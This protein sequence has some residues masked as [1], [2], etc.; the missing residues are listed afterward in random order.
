MLY[1][2]RIIPYNLVFKKP[3]KTSRNTFKEKTVYYLKL[4]KTNHPEKFGIGE[5]A[6]LALLSLDDDKEFE[7][8]FNNII[9]QFCHKG[10]FEPFWQ[11]KYPSM[12]FAL[13][14]A[15]LDLE[16]GCCRR[17][18]PNII[19][20]ELKIMI[21]GLVWMNDADTMLTEALEL[22]DK[23]YDCIKFKVGALDFDSEC[24]LLE[25]FRKKHSV[26][27][28]MIRL[29]ANGAFHPKEAKEQLK[30]L[31]KFGI[32]SIEQP[33]K[34]EFMDELSELSAIRIIDIALDESLIGIADNSQ[35]IDLLKNIKPQYL[36]LKPTLLGGLA[37]TQQ[38]IDLGKKMQI[39][40]WITSALESNIGLN[41]IAQF[42]AIQPQ[43]KHSYHGLGT[44]S[45]YENNIRSPWLAEAGNLNYSNDSPWD[46][47]MF[48]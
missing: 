35:K 10:Q 25:K 8:T 17:L 34:P 30:E 37:Q 12:A 21:N 7:F 29:D 47:S 27:N 18:Y 4:S 11:H 23:G 15:L 16:N 14:T 20:E 45:L 41:A 32:H 33:I 28:I 43:I 48:N 26:G 24:R 44:G 36:V 31:K 38:W 39:A 42:A 40:N 46:F 2:Y 9:T 13:E 19:E 5:A 1:K 6:P 3:A 22:V